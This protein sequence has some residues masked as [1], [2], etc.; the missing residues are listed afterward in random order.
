MNGKGLF[1]WSFNMSEYKTIAKIAFAHLRT[2]RKSQ[3]IAKDVDANL[4]RAAELVEQLVKRSR[5]MQTFVAYSNNRMQGN[6]DESKADL[7]RHGVM[8]VSSA[9]ESLQHAFNVVKQS[10][11]TMQAI[12]T[13]SHLYGPESRARANGDKDDVDV[14]VK[15]ETDETVSLRLGVKRARS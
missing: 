4:T 1:Q 14:D 2:G 15:Q 6:V 11:E 7:V 12:N 9:M 10:I 3:V 8:H 13:M 5:D